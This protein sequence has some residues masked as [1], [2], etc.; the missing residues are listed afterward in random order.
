MQKLD[1][2]TATM[3]Q[4]RK[5]NFQNLRREVD[6]CHKRLERGWAQVY[7]SGVILI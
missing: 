7:F 6:I 5:D 1:Q 3:T 4:W 2:C